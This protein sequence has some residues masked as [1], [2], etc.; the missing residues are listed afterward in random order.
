MLLVL[1]EE[2]VRQVGRRG[3]EGGAPRQVAQARVRLPLAGVVVEVRDQTQAQ[4]VGGVQA[5]DDAQVAGRLGQA[6]PEA[7]AAVVHRQ[8][9]SV[10]IT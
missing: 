8:G 2:R 4:R 6:L 1:E 7:Q 10:K 5:L 3:G 9:V